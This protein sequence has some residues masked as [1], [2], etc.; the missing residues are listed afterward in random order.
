MYDEVIDFLKEKGFDDIEWGDDFGVFYEIV[1]VEYYDKL[2]FIICY[3]MFL[4]LFYMQFVFDCDD[5][6]FC[7]DL[8]VLEGYGEI[9][10]GFEWIYD[11]EFLEVCFKEY[12]LDFDVYK[13]Y[14]EFRKY[15]LVFYFGFGFG[16][17]WI[18]VWISGV[19]YVCEI[20]LFLRLLN[21]LYL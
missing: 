2:V 3:L 7:V 13:W 21:C 9:I 4:K 1:I 17:E 15:G 11:M 6:V 14:V 8:I 16:L 5:V 12:G 20:I 10:G 19:F 18:V